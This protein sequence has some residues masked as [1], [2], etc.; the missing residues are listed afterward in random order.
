MCEK[1]AET[2]YSEALDHLCCYA[3]ILKSHKWI[4]WGERES[5]IL[6]HQPP[7]IFVRTSAEANIGSFIRKRLS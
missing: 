3:K 4:V 5:K 1:A 2:K 6:K 7:N